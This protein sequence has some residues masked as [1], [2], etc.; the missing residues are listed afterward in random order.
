MA[1]TFIAR[2]LHRVGYPTG[3]WVV[4]DGERRRLLSILR[5]LDR[6]PEATPEEVRDNRRDAPYGWDSWFQYEGTGRSRRRIAV[7]D[8]RRFRGHRESL[9]EVAVPGGYRYVWA[10][11][12]E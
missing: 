4:T 1:E 11:F 6:L 7:I 10:P 5:K 9:L 8:Y 12:V 3:G 2:I